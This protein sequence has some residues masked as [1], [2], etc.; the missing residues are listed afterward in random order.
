MLLGLIYGMPGWG[1]ILIIV[2]LGVLILGGKRLPELGKSLG[3]SIVEFKNGLIGIDKNLDREDSD[4]V[5]HP[6]QPKPT[7][8]TKHD[9]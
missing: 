9:R 4:R 5:S 7:G 6:T 2:S 1:E 3:R 8:P